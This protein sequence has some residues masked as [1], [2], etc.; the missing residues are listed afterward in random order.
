MV[1][2]CSGYCAKLTIMNDL[3]SIF[4]YFVYDKDL[5]KSIQIKHNLIIIRHFLLS[6]LDSCS[7]KYPKPKSVKL[8]HIHVTVPSGDAISCSEGSPSDESTDVD[9]DTYH[10]EEPKI[11][12]PDQ[13][14]S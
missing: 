11:H 7:K 3:L 6:Q 14:V 9:K 4:Y 2:S 8:S 1:I 5:H 10:I 13:L 12:T